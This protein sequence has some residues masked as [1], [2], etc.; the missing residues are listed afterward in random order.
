MGL[1][2]G[3]R[4]AVGPQ[5]SWQEQ[6]ASCSSQAGIGPSAP[7]KVSLGQEH[8]QLNH[9]QEGRPENPGRGATWVGAYE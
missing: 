2:G 6:H 3:R 7:G 5:T 8:T 1:G 9:S 4:I